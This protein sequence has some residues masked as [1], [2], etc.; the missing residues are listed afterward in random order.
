[1]DTMVRFLAGQAAFDLSKAGS[2]ELGPLLVEPPLRRISAG[3]RHDS[4]E[5]RVMRVLVALAEAR[6]KVLSRDDLIYACWDG[7]IVGDNA[8]NRVM[9]RLRAVLKTLSDGAVSVETITK[10]GFRL[11]TATDEPQTGMA[12]DRPTSDAQGWSRR[13]LVLGGLAAALVAGGGLFAFAIGPRKHKPHPRALDLWRR[14]QVMMKSVEPGTMG[15]A[16]SF[17]KQAVQIDPQFADAW[18]SL[19]VGYQHSMQGFSKTDATAFPQLLDSAAKRALALDPA[20]PDAL[21][22]LALAKLRFGRWADNDRIMRGLVERVPNYWYA[23]AKMGIVLRETGRIGE[24]LVHSKRV[25]ELDPMLPVGWQFVARSQAMVGEL[26]Q[27]DLT[28]DRAFHQW[29]AHGLLWMAR[30][31]ILLESGRFGEAAA[32]ARDPRSM[33]DYFKG[34][35]EQFYAGMAGAL[36]AQDRKGI[37]KSIDGIRKL[38]AKDP[39]ATPLVTPLLAVLGAGDQALTALQRYFAQAMASPEA[40]VAPAAAALFRPSIL[41]LRADPRYAAILRDIALEDHWRQRGSPPDF[42]RG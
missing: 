21:T 5:P 4:L 35:R 14:G 42:R 12:P 32:F 41:K 13:G 2:F 28:L 22:A 31:D 7:Q 8:I 38:I 30:F 25:L 34:E 37:A 18:G 27:A 1:M 33:P 29:P 10:V 16:M 9:S 24:S 23:Q 3:N 26:Q 20:Q 36:A 39:P 19:A 15:Q 17:Y 11:Q 6:P 40:I